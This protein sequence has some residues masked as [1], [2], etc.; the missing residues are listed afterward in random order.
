MPELLSIGD[1]IQSRREA[2]GLSRL[3]LARRSK[4]SHEGL[5][6]IET[7]IVRNPGVITAA[8]LAR[9]LGISIDALLT[10]NTSE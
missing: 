7:G 6:H 5:R 3:E 4:V 8:A 1:A 2:A 10:S 9:S